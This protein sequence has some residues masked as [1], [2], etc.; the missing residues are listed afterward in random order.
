[1]S[2]DRKDLRFLSRLHRRPRHTVEA[3]QGGQS[4]QYAMA[5]AGG[6]EGKGQV[7][8]SLYASYRTILAVVIVATTLAGTALADPFGDALSATANE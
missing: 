6:G 2:S 3:R 1:V 4:E 7:G 8:M 5:D